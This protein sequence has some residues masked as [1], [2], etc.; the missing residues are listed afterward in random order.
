MKIVWSVTWTVAL[1]AVLIIELVLCINFDRNC[2]GYLKRAADANT[3]QLAEE[4]LAID[5]RLS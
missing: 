3:I 4:N 5:Q 1:L 2:G